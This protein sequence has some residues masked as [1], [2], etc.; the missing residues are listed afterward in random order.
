M[1]LL[2]RSAF[3]HRRHLALAGGVVG[4]F[5][6]RKRIARERQKAMTAAAAATVAA[7]VALT[8]AAERE[9]LRQG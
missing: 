2:L 7:L 8:V 9:R 4:R 6:L 5:L 3:R 1:I